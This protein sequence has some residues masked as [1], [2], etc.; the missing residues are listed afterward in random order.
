MKL[1]KQMLSD[2]EKEPREDKVM[3]MRAWDDYH[4]G[5]ADLR[6]DWRKKRKVSAPGD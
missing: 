1:Y 6:I 4:D 5:P 2:M 3:F